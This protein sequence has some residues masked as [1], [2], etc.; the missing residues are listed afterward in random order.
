M[1]KEKKEWLVDL[2]LSEISQDDL[3]EQV[4]KGTNKSDKAF[5]ISPVPRYRA[6]VIFLK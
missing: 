3:N 1:N 6:L 5:I 2:I 4:K